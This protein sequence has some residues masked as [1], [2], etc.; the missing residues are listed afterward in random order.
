[1]KKALKDPVVVQVNGEV[2]DVR[3]KVVLVRVPSL[4][5]LTGTNEMAAELKRAGAALVFYA[6]PQA[7]LETLDDD[8]LGRLGL[9]RKKD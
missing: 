6:D 2:V 7:S 4:D 8:D 9:L 1:M 3:D 5:D